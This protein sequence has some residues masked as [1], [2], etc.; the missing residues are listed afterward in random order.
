MYLTHDQLV[1]ALTPSHYVTILGKLFTR[2]ATTIR[3]ENLVLN[4]R[5]QYPAA[6][7]VPLIT[8][9]TSHGHVSQVNSTP[10]YRLPCLCKEDKNF[11]NEYCIIILQSFGLHM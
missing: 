6:G 3:Q 9:L 4:K 10:I 5:L 2:H 7:K 1:V 8:D 11:S